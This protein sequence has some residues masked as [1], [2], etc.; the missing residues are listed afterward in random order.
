M[1]TSFT[2]S[3]TIA[4]ASGPSGGTLGGTLVASATSGVATFGSLTLNKVGSYALAVT[5]G[6]LTA[7]T[8]NSISVTPS[9]A[10]Q[11][12]ITTQ[13]PTTVAWAARSA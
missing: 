5:S 13:P 8:S 3:E 12:L 7:A 2:G 1:A 11:L 10:T 6:T 4:V 9:V